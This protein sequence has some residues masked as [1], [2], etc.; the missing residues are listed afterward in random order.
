[1]AQ[2]PYTLL[3]KPVG[4]DCNLRCTY[5]FYLR[6]LDRVYSDKPRHLMTQDTLRRLIASY[7]GEG[8]RSSAFCWQGGEPLLAGLD[9][10]ERA[11]EFQKRF[12]A[13]GRVVSNAFQTN[14]TL[15]DA[16]WAK[17]FRQYNCLLG[18]SIDGPESIH[19]VYRVTTAGRGSHDQTI[20]A[21]DVLR[22]YEVEFNILCTVNRKTADHPNE[23]LD[24]FDSLGVKYLQ[25]IPLVEVDPA[26]GSVADYVA[27]PEQYGKFLCDLWDEWVK[28][29]I[30]QISIRDF[31]AWI[32]KML[33]GASPLCCYD[34]ACNQYVMV[35]HTG[36]VY[37][38][39]F[40]CNPAYKLGNLN[41][42]PLA[43]IFRSPKHRGFA[44]LKTVYPDECYS[45]Q[46]LSLCHGGCTKDRMLGDS[47]AGI[48]KARASNYFCQS[49]KMFFDHA[50]DEMV[51][52]KNKIWEIETGI[53]RG[54]P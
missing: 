16:K 46:W 30:P 5:C 40:Y 33:G 13:D 41:E 29:G 53:S 9:F 21:L 35:E 20:R 27:T 1:M 11:V 2:K 48:P 36:D 10:Y 52:L 51:A 17:F 39:D 25:F 32:E 49:Y 37:P 42:T 3:I 26:T 7:M 28:P 34:S 54:T 14:A 43:Q 24:Y 38:C 4:G 45:C 22:E 44:A 12:G 15:I 6:T 19:D 50:Y 31:E 47:S 8:F 18:V 23:I